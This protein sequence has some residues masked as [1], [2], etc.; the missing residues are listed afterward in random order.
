[1]R[2]IPFWINHIAEYELSLIDAAYSVNVYIYGMNPIVEI[3]QY[4]I[5]AAY[6]VIIY[7]RNKPHQP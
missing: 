7:P 4:M 3:D 5:D 2:F 6:S 1:M